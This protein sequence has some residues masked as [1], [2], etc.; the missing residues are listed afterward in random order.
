MTAAAIA[1]RPLD[2]ARI[3][4]SGRPWSPAA[5]RRR[6][7]ITHVRDRHDGL[8]VDTADTLDELRRRLPRWPGRDQMLAII[9]QII[10]HPAIEKAR[11]RKIGRDGLRAIW[12]NDI[13]DA[14]QSGGL[15]RTSRRH[16]ADRVG[17]KDGEKTVQKARQIGRY[18]GLYVELYRGRE[19]TQLE[20]VTLWHG[21]DRHKQ[22][23]FTSIFAV[24]VFAPRHAEQFTTP[25]P[26]Q[27]VRIHMV[28][29]SQVDRATPLPRSGSLFDLPHLLQMVTPTAADAA[30]KLKT[31]EGSTTRRKPR[32]GL[33]LAVELLTDPM[34]ARVFA[35]IRP[36]RIAG[37]LKPY[38]Q[39]GWRA[40]ALTAAL[41]REASTLRVSPWESARS[42]FGLLKTLL[43]G[44]GVI[45]DVDA[46]VYGVIPQAQPATPPA[47]PC[48]RPECDG[49][50]WI[51]TVTD[52]GHNIAR[53]CP[54]CPPLVR[55]G[56]QTYQHEPLPF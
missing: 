30:R 21:H 32:P 16:A 29:P 40:G 35:G 55:A 47:E 22:R 50:G 12:F 44:V 33:G 4:E 41:R 48:G 28:N 49:Y 25:K 18:A 31:K 1:S 43:R 24:G 19:L 27:F 2:Y 56:R 14:A 54:H 7:A 15:L 17:Y 39:A 11:G 23:G 6:Q 37:Q 34:L 51:N 46:A 52:A 45:P 9:D 8:D 13:I 53:P 5:L 20:R 42:P 36:G 3:P 26:G 10:D 38:E